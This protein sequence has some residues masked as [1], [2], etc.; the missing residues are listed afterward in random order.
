[1]AGPASTAAS[2]HRCSRPSGP[3]P[4]RSR[5]SSSAAP[6]ASSS[7]PRTCSSNSGTLRV[8]STPSDSDRPDDRDPPSPRRQRGRR[9]A[10]RGVRQRLD[11]GDARLR[12]LRRPQRARQ[13]P[14]VRRRRRRPA[15]PR[16]QPGLRAHHD[17]PRP[18]RRRAQRHMEARSSA[19]SIE[20][21]AG[22]TAWARH[23]AAPV[24]DY[25]RTETGGALVLLAAVLAGLAWANIDP[26]SYRSL[27]STELEVRVGGHALVEDLRH[28]IND[29]LMVFFFFIV[30]LEA[31]RELDQGELRERRRIA[32]PVLAAIGGVSMPILIYLALNAGGDAAHG[33]GAAMSTDTAF[34]LGALALVGPRCPERLRV[35]L[36][37]VVVV[38]DLA[39]LLVIAIAYSERLSLTW[40]AIAV[41]LLGVFLAIGKLRVWRGPAYVVA[42]GGIWLAMHESGIHPTIAGLAMGLATSAY[43]P[44]RADLEDVT[45]RVRE[46]REQPT[47]ELAR[48]TRIRLESAVSPN[49]RLQLML[50][51]WTSFVIVPLFA[52]AN[53]GITLDSQLVRDAVRSPV[54]LGIF[55]GYVA[56]KTL[57]IL[58]AS[59]VATRRGL[60]PPVGWGALAGGGA[61][62]GIGF[63]VSLLIA[64]LAFE[65][66]RLE[67]AKLGILGAAI[68]AS[69]LG[70]LA[71][72]V[73][74]AL[75][76]AARARELAGSA[77]DILDLATPVDPERDH[78]RGPQDAPVTLI[79]YGDFE[80]PYCGQ[81]EP[82]L[83]QL[84]AEQGDDLRFVFRHLPLS[85]VHEHAQLAAEAAEAAGAQGAFWQ[86]HDE[87]LDHQD[88][89]RPRELVTAGER[90]GLDAG[91]LRDELR[92]RVYA[93]RVAEDVHEADESGVTG[94][95][96][97][98]V[99]GRRHHGAYDLQ[100]LSTAVR[101][102]RARALR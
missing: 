44:A 52:L 85:D 1:M 94:T 46:F 10:E 88:A 41:G 61:V 53:A 100:T 29:G 19:L 5:T 25:L 76:A 37:T 43:L 101:Q 70:W 74:D 58:G 7:A 75:P 60:R 27:W 54:T 56:G 87:L 35:F 39:A 64:S 31:R 86:M 67:Q 84:L 77:E 98:F 15:L 65:G 33:W 91:R 3:A 90:L 83:R 49:E 63:T 36:L 66:E 34:A 62:A 16:L 59:W 6:P 68:A 14:R 79:E 55:F 13:P 51:P 47:P 22:R 96:T 78:I 71:F 4:A 11:R 48:S 93:P 72:R 17:P 57:G 89:L 24:R 8:R 95:P 38:D 45:A 20:G 92:R 12:A 97:F 2:T 102:A 32:L 99:N 26:D 80:C 9:P 23:L 30:G 40:L 42:G 73:I 21:F 18:P 28:W 81:A 50:H 69:A 82:V